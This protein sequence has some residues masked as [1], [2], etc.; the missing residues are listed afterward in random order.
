MRMGEI[1]YTLVEVDDDT[2]YDELADAFNEMIDAAR[3]RAGPP[4][5]ADDRESD[6]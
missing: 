5:L 1:V 2:D 3:A 6:P 4:T